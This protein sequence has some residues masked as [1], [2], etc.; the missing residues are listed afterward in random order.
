MG[1]FF[2]AIAVLLLVAIGLDHFG[3]VGYE[4][5]PIT[6][7][8]VIGAALILLGIALFFFYR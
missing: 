2:L 8:R 5:R 6:T 7:G 1:W 4:I 3:L